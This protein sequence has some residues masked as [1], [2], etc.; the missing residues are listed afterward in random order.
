MT[1]LKTP[2]A[3]RTLEGL[4]IFILTVFLLGLFVSRAALSIAM[5]SFIAL[6]IFYKIKTPSER[7]NLPNKQFAFLY[8][9]LFLMGGLS[10]FYSSNTPDYWNYMRVWLPMLGLPFAFFTLPVLSA[11]NFFHLLTIYV[12]IVVLGVFWSLG[13]FAANPI[14]IIESYEHAKVMPT[15]LGGDHIRFSLAVVLG[16]SI[17]VV[18]AMVTDQKK[19]YFKGEK[20]V[21]IFISVFLFLYLHVLAV[22]SGL[23]A[24][25]M[26][27]AWL[28]LF[29]FFRKN[30]KI[31]AL[32]TS[33]LIITPLLSYFF[34]PTFQ[35]KLGYIKY[36][37]A[38]H[39]ETGRVEYLSDVNRLVS[40]EL[41][42]KKTVENPILGVGLGD[43]NDETKESYR[44][45]Y[46]DVP[47]KS[48][49]L[50]HNQWLL[51]GLA[52][53]F[54][55]MII[56]TM[57]YLFPLTIRTY[58]LSFMGVTLSLVGLVALMVEPVLMT[59]YGITT[60]MFLQLLFF[61]NY[62]S[63]SNRDTKLLFACE[64]F[65]VG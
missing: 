55:G 33:I 65:E 42:W 10:F 51:N 59:Q 18:L 48:M 44:T 26:V 20:N 62:T 2:K 49:L 27:Y 54:P 36:E 53:G 13:Q 46:P 52:L 56:L 31:S 3:R 29:F 19:V 15:P 22:K 38:E 6:A 40:Y 57:L 63:K 7:W 32:L 8:L 12:L 35:Q 1:P 14:A 45:F 28:S 25:W 41:A 60:Y 5:I 11:K 43:I 9:A 4:Y 30:Y 21:W 24:G 39:K 61:S 58:R 64:K 17:A 34:V 23:L 47:E 50:P 37:F 16:A